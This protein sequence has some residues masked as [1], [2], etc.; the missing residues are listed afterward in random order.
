MVGKYLGSYELVHSSVE[1]VFERHMFF[2]IIIEQQ[3]SAAVVSVDRKHKLRFAIVVIVTCVNQPHPGVKIFHCPCRIDHEPGVID[4]ESSLRILAVDGL[5]V[6]A[7]HY[8]SGPG[9]VRLNQFHVCISIGKRLHLAAVGTAVTAQLR[10]LFPELLP[11]RSHPILARSEWL[12]EVGILDVRM[13]VG[14]QGPINRATKLARELCGSL[15]Y[16]WYH[17]RAN[18]LFLTHTRVPLIFCRRSARNASQALAVKCDC[19]SFFLG[20]LGWDL[21]QTVLVTT[22]AP[23]GPPVRTVLVKHDPHGAEV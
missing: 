1:G 4:I 16:R 13:R 21:F 7:R 12:P 8:P 11:Q 20:V 18:D 10:K 6:Q 2:E 17:T 3:I 19:P 9:A 14:H 22:V 15:S 23:K 5:Q